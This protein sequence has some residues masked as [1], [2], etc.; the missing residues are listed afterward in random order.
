[1]PEVA[2]KAAILVDPYKTEEIA[3]AMS[4]LASRDILRSSLI[5]KGI[6]R[7]IDFDWRIAAEKTLEV[8]T[9]K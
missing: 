1:M 7:S 2:G 3:D 8:I 4:Q 5:K 6:L 9:G